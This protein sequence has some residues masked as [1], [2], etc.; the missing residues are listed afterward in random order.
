MNK[1]VYDDVGGRPQRKS[2]DEA[3][4]LLAEAGYPS[5]RETKT[6][7]PL[8]LHYDSMVGAG[9]DPRFDW[10]RR[11]LSRIGVQLD[12]RATDYNRFQDK[13]RRGAAQLFL[14]GWKADYPDAENFLFLL[15]GPNA[16]ADH[17]GEN[18]S[19]YANPEYDKL[20]ERMKTLDD[21][22]EKEQLIH[23]MTA[24]VQRDAPWMFGY[25]P[26]SGG[27]YHQWVGNAKP[28]QMVRNTLQYMKIDPVLR[29]AKI[30]EWNNPIWWPLI[31]LA[32]VVA[33]A[34]LP[35]YI[36]YRRR[37]KRTAFGAAARATA[38]DSA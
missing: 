7:A 17:N 10:M 4:R 23:Q 25:F 30:R 18:A 22:P 24:L 37:A 27:A 9:A 3:R 14:W 28:T 21:G 20:F 8:V 34:I 35:A 31:V 26:F 16:K 13:M 32:L 36:T 19:N 1:T 2:L 38:K 29:D 12:V 6:G 5:G 11:Q 33:L 15:Y